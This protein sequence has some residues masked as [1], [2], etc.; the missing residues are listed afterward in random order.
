MRLVKAH[1][2]GQHVHVIYI[3]LFLVEGRHLQSQENIKTI[4]RACC[5]CMSFNTA[6]ADLNEKEHFRLQT[7]L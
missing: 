2:S 4:P 6:R 7:P 5:A 3:G 1:V